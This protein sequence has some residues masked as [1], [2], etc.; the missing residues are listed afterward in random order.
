MTCL[1]EFDEREIEFGRAAVAMMVEGYTP[2]RCHWLVTCAML[3][4]RQSAAV[5]SRR[6][7]LRVVD[8]VPPIA[9]RYPT[10]IVR[11]LVAFK[12][13]ARSTPASQ[14]MQSVVARLS[15]EEMIAVAAYAA[16][17]RPR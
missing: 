1:T 2:D 7:A 6:D 11:Q 3:A 4:S 16:S 5:Q 9:G 17:L 10:Y 12:T 15:V 14:P 13:G 8:A